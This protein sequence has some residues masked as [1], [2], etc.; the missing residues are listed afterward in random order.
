VTDEETIFAAALGK[1]S[2]AE[3]D[4]YLDHA[5]GGD[6]AL[7]AQ[8]DALLF[9]HARGA[10]VLETSP[11]GDMSSAA[12]A[13]LAGV[14]VGLVIGPYKLLEQIGGGG[15]GVVFMAEQLRPVRRKVALKI[16]KPGMDS[17]QVIARFE[18]ERQA[19]TM[20]DHPNIAKVLDAGTTDAGRPY[21]VMELVKGIPITDYCDQARLTPRQRLE[22]FVTVCH[23]VQHAHQKGVIHR[24]LKP[25]NVLVT[26]H[27][28]KPVPKVIDFGIAKATGQV[29]TDKTLFTNYAQMLGTPLYMSPEQAQISGLDVDT[30]SDVY[31][32]GV[33]LYELLTGTTPFDKQRLRDA[34]YD[35]MRRI[36]REEDPPKP[37]TRISTMGEPATAMSARRQ[38]DPK[39]LGQLVRGELDWIVMKALEKARARRYETANDLGHDVERYLRDEPV[40]AC[41]PSTWY[42]CWK[43]ARRNKVALVA[44]TVVAV[45]V[46]TAVA[47]LA[48]STVLI[49]REQRITAAAYAAETRATGELQ[50]TANSHRITLAY[51]ELAADNL[52]RTLRLL[53]DCP[54]ELRN[55]EWHYLNRLCRVEPVVLRDACEV[56]AVAFAP[57]GVRVAA[58][59]GDNT[60][61]VWDTATQKVVQTLSGHQAYVFSVAYSMDGRHIASAGHDGTVRLW[62]VASG[63]ELFSRPGH[64]GDYAGTAGALAFSPDGRHLAAGG[65]DGFATIWDVSDGRA[66]LRL[67][68]KHE[69]TA[70]CVAFSPDGSLIA[71]GS[72][73]GVVRVF[74]ARNG[75]LRGKIKGHGHR[76]AGVVFSPDGKRVA[77]AS[78]DRTLKVW[79]APALRLINTLGVTPGTGHTGVITGLAVSGDGG[80]LFSSGGEDKTVKVWDPQSGEE[81]LNLRGHSLFCHGLAASADG[82]RLASAGRDGTIRIWDAMRLSG[83]EGAG[84]ITREHGGEVWSVE[85]SSNGQYLASGTW[86]ENKVRV[87]DGR[88]DTLRHTVA[89]APD[90]MNLFHCGFSSDGNRIVTSSASYVREA[91]VNVWDARTG[92]SV[93]GEVREK[94]TMPFFAALDPSG[95]YLVREGPEFAVQVHDAGTG[96][97][98]GIVG[99]HDNQIWGMA[100][101]ADGARLATASNDGTVRVWAW[102]PKHLAVN[103]QPELKLAVRVDGYGNRVAFSR[104]GKHLATG[105]EGSLVDIWDAQTGER[106]HRLAGHTGDVF[107]LA[108]SP[109]ARWLATAGEDTTVRIWDAARWTLRRTLRGHTG[110]VMSVAFSPDSHRLASGSRDHTMKVWDTAGWDDVPER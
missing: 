75:E 106:R 48:T 56:Y 17:R 67:P 41:P 89:L 90:V 103:Q 100:F 82:A 110:L 63:R 1:P 49:T 19:L 24:D 13:A 27:D 52:G 4:A 66:V 83:S 91:V 54:A 84:S 10:G 44:A 20:M 71:T 88:G 22:L 59:C 16:I 62:D 97:V 58:A 65:E 26:L 76:L 68:E 18:A 23:A 2:S 61:K 85:F 77:S 7:R 39:R 70:V 69:K 93:S 11:L 36:L 32:L 81:V 98:L 96:Q 108:F 21:F 8:V 74:D 79:E 34:A 78:F 92:R 60:V 50:H 9:A 12:A 64:L 33:L 31:S 15:M 45:G 30:R 86:G 6:A 37:S 40:Q 95:R 43:F 14:G 25:T 105:G 5:C 94:N 53:D 87:W 38:T 3:R 55:W 109:D 47:G 42:R 102:D 57:D 28:D 101:S 35:E 46:L 104:D 29:L 73:G 72:W 80:R 107:A 51:R 99:K